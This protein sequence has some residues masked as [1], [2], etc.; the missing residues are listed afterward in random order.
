MPD[1]GNRTSGIAAA[2][3]PTCAL[4]LITAP[5]DAAIQSTPPPS[6]AG[7]SPVLPKD[8]SSLA[9]GAAIANSGSALLQ[10]EKVSRTSSSS[11]LPSP[12]L[13]PSPEKTNLRLRRCFR[14]RRSMSRRRRAYKR[15]PRP[16]CLRPLG[17]CGRVILPP[18]FR[19]PA[20]PGKRN[21]PRNCVVN[22]M[23]QTIVRTAPVFSMAACWRGRRE[24]SSDRFG[25]VFRMLGRRG[26]T[27]R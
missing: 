6:Q 10:D 19:H 12:M 13:S 23:C 21:L 2:V 14:R 1:R 22:Q 27:N 20:R 8:S 5:V 16:S 3:S 24:P 26:R 11:S 25:S 9:T 7:D 4:G 15:W 18:P 17:Y